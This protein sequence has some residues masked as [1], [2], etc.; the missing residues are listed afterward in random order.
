VSA[1]ARRLDV[2]I[3][4]LMRVLDGRISELRRFL[5]DAFFADGVALP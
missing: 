5:F 3:A 4:L 1:A 2:V